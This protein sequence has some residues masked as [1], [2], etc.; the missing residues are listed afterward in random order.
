[1]EALPRG[2]NFVRAKT[3]WEIGL[4]V[5]GNPATP[6]GGNRD[7]IIAVG[8][9]SGASFRPWLRLATG[10]AILAEEVASGGVELAFVNPAALLTQAFRGVGLFPAPLPV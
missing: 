2:A 8:S 5:A 1:M 10:S 4:H 7:M 9:G 3:L 6:Y